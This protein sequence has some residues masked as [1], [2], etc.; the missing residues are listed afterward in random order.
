MVF[1]PDTEQSQVTAAPQTDV[2]LEEPVTETQVAEESTSIEA[3]TADQANEFTNVADLRENLFNQ[4]VDESSND[5]VA[6]QVQASASLDEEKFNKITNELREITQQVQSNTFNVNNISNALDRLQSQVTTFSNQNKSFQNNLQNLSS[7]I[8]AVNNS[9]K[10]LRKS[11]T[12]EDYLYDDA[13]NATD[14]NLIAQSKRAKINTSGPMYSIHAII[15]GRVWLKDKEG[16][17]TSYMEGDILSDR[18]KIVVID[19]MNYVVMTST[20]E[21]YR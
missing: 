16:V 14:A 2:I 10:A 17:I 3:D 9:I 15:P 20:G 19:P 18:G 11:L 1:V 8:A 12:S 5:L 4:F 7:E 21:V 6:A 13:K